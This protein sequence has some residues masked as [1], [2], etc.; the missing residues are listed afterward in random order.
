MSTVCRN[1]V[2]GCARV[3]DIDPTHGLCQ[4]CLAVTQNTE[5]ATE[6]RMNSMRQDNIGRQ[7]N[8]RAE[9]T[10]AHRVIND[11]QEVS[12][13]VDT[14]LP[15]VDLAKAAQTYNNIRSGVSV[16]QSEVMADVLGLLLQ[17]ANK[18]TDIEGVKSLA[19][20]NADS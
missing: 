18:N 13:N 20:Q 15:T 7:K 11:S 10:N 12:D 3:K 16:D 17:Q 9:S 19:K 2:H 6:D 4:V 1:K 14:G 5:K 8:A